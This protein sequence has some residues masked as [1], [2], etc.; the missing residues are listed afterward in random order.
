MN[1]IWLFLGALVISIGWF[2]GMRIT[3][4]LDKAVWKAVDD[5]KVVKAYIKKKNSNKKKSTESQET[6]IGF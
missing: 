3:Q 1:I 5:S 6:K 2:T 4:M